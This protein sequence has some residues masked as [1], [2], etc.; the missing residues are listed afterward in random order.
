[1]KRF[2]IVFVW[3]P[4]YELATLGDAL[5][6]NSIEFWTGENPIDTSTAMAAKPPRVARIEQGD[7]VAIL[8]YQ[9]GSTNPHLVI[10][11]FHQNQPAASVRIE[12]R[13]DVTVAV[14][15]AGQTLWTAHTLPDGSLAIHDAQGQPVAFYSADRVQQI[16]ASARQ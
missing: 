14:D 9:T 6:F 5:V 13:G 2:F 16:V 11:Q 1:M 12:P 10:E 4:V 8:T 3:V 15:A 7:D